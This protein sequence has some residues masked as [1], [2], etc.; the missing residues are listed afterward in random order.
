M[1]TAVLA[2]AALIT[3]ASLATGTGRA[4]LDAARYFAGGNTEAP[5]LQSGYSDWKVAK[6]LEKAGL[7]TGD[8]VGGMG[9]TFGAFWARMARVRIVAEVPVEGVARFWSLDSA[10]RA[11][12]MKLFEVVGAK[13]VVTSHGPGDAEPTGW[14]RVG[15][16]RF[17]VYLF[18]TEG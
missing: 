5:L 17:Y 14:K 8:A 3:T 16:T 10:N 9:W 18:D 4:V 1:N 2:A 11:V 15:D 13:A 6:Y 12:V 7:R